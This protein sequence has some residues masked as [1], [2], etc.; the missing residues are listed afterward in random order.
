[1]IVIQP[2]EVVAHRADAPIQS[3]RPVSLPPAVVHEPTQI[4]D[5]DEPNRYVVRKEPGEFADIGGK[6]AY[7][8]LFFM[9]RREIVPIIAQRIDNEL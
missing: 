4:I 5:A 3:L 7:S 8:A 9:G 1:M 6:Q 2:F